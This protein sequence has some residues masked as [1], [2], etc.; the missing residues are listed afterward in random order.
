MRVQYE[1]NGKYDRFMSRVGLNDTAKLNESKV[2]FEVL[3]DDK[4]LWVSKDVTKPKNIQSF[5]ISVLDINTLELRVHCDGSNEYAHAVWIDPVIVSESEFSVWYRK[6]YGP[7][8]VKQLNE[9]SKH[10]ALKLLGMLADAHLR[11]LRCPPSRPIKRHT[12]AVLDLEEP[13]II[14]I[15]PELFEHAEVLLRNVIS[16]KLSQIE[17]HDLEMYEAVMLLLCANLQRLKFSYVNPASVFGDH[18]DDD[19]DENEE[20]KEE[21]KKQKEE[22]DADYLESLR[23][24]LLKIIS[25][26][27]ES[28]FSKDLPA[29]VLYHGR[30]IFFPSEETRYE[31]A[32]QASKSCRC[33]EF[34]MFWPVLSKDPSSSQNSKHDG[35]VF[36]A[37]ERAMLLLQIYCR[38][39]RWKTS[40]WGEWMRESHLVIEIP[41]SSSSSK[42]LRMSFYVRERFF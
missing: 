37:Y 6:V 2:R 10:A 33:I 34:E 19:D 17:D 1:L 27:K 41:S 8:G 20:H 5:D 16:K 40:F 24:L 3:G 28:R 32:L 15:C 21:E 42:L 9:G 13:Y 29:E 30:R 14:E 38:D 12:Q 39:R 25:F 35:T 7:I 26:P 18:D 36:Q 31:M 11:S 23:N 4:I 22:K